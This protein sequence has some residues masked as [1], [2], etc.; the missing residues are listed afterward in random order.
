MALSGLLHLIQGILTLGGS[1]NWSI[2]RENILSLFIIQGA[3]LTV[4]IAAISQ[5]LG[6]LIGLALYFLRRAPF[7]VV[8]WLAEVY[9]WFFRGTPLLVQILVF[10]NF[11]P[12]VRLSQPLRQIDPFTPLG[13]QNVFMDAFLSAIFVLALN[14]GAYMAEIVRAGID[15][16][17]IGQLE[18][19]KSL[20]MT[21]GMAMRR[22]VLPQAMR[23]IIPPLGNEFNN[24]LKNTSLAYTITLPEL[25]GAATDIGASKFAL[26]ELYVAVLPWYLLLTSAWGYVQAQIERKL[27]ASNLDPALRSRPSWWQRAMGLGARAPVGAPAGAGTGVTL[28][29]D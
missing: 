8:R 5:L 24:M 14:E 19:A 26:L 29:H 3:I 2:V 17:D 25:L 21:Y 18:A 22:I 1:F 4:V 9:I 27:N 23:V 15:S 13:F 7:R 6:T 28:E 11:L 20:G 16:I 12:A 10:Y